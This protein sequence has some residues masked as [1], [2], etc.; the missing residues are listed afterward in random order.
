MKDTNK[1]EK[2]AYTSHK[3]GSEATK[4]EIMSKFAEKAFGRRC[5]HVKK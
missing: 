2:T 4:A 5:G 1:Q 3:K